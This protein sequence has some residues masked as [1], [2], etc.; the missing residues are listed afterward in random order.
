[1]SELLKTVSDTIKREQLLSVREKVIVAISGGA[2]SVALLMALFSLDFQVVAAH[3]NFHLRGDESDGDEEYVRQLCKTLG[4]EIYV[5]D[6]DTYAYAGER[7]LSVE[8]AARELRYTWFDELCDNL[9]IGKRAVAHHKND[10]V[11]TVLL[12]LSMGTGIRGVRGMRYMRDGKIIRPLLDVSREEI[13]CFL[14]EQN[15]S[16]RE[17]STNKEF[18]YKRNALR[19]KIIPAF[20]A[21]NPAF[22]ETVARTARNLAGVEELY[23]YTLRKIRCEVQTDSGFLIQPLKAYPALD[24]ILY[25][26]LRE[27]GFNR[28]Q[29][30]DIRA[31]LDNPSGAV[32]FSATHCL[33]RGRETLELIRLDDLRCDMPPVSIDLLSGSGRVEL[34][35]G[36]VFWKKLRRDEFSS[37]ERNPNLLYLDARL[38]PDRLL[39]RKVHPGDRI[40]PFGM[41]GTKKVSR[42]FIDNHIS[43]RERQ[44]TFLLTCGDFV[45]WIPGRVVSDRFRIDENTQNIFVFTFIPR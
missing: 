29:C 22:V 43:H 6:F 11:E 35:L 26:L 3:C 28:L 33:I 10:Q 25:E 20:T 5:K 34:P 44:S 36:D 17:D 37:F 40:K 16:Y 23:N 19:H 45:L 18:V 13:E 15:L 32:F 30:A 4:I 38:L 27:Y 2:D 9:G 24:T 8:M 12:N 41:K 21:L 1:M 42:I 39:F 7:S 14:Q 31:S